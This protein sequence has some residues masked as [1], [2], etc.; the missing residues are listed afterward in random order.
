MSRSVGIAGRCQQQIQLDSGRSS[1]HPDEGCA[2]QRFYWRHCLDVRL[3]LFALA[4]ALSVASILTV[5][6]VADRF[7]QATQYSGQRFLGA[8]RVLS[9][10]Q[11]IAKT[12][13]QHAQQLGRDSKCGECGTY[14]GDHFELSSVRAV[15][16]AYPFYGELVF[17]PEKIT[18]R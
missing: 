9:D 17:R 4:L 14:V 7:N 11:S 8:D 15:G 12:W 13:Q 18:N 6:L 2:D 10:N 3:I 16:D 1:S 5:T